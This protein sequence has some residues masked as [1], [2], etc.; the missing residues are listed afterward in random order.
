MSCEI[1]QNL[2]EKWAR[3]NP[4]LEISLW[5]EKTK[6]DNWKIVNLKCKRHALTLKV[7]TSGMALF[8]KTWIDGYTGARLVAL[9]EHC[10]GKPHMKDLRSFKASVLKMPTEVG[11]KDIDTS[12]SADEMK[13][14]ERKANI[15]YFAAKN[16]IPF[17][18]F[19]GLVELV[20]KEGNLNFEKRTSETFIRE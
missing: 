5:L 9:K 4:S 3:E 10:N 17:R 16:D 15:A 13:R 19:Q 1:S 18:T 8:K 11:Q 20:H 12:V 6:N 14:L 7:K 2:I